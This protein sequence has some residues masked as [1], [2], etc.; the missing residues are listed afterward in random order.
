MV[1]KR[2]GIIFVN[3][4]VLSL[5]I[6]VILLLGRYFCTPEML[7]YAERYLLKEI[8][9]IEMEFDKKIMDELLG[10][11][12]TS[13]AET[14]KGNM[15]YRSAWQRIVEET[16]YKENQAATVW[17]FQ[18][19]ELLR[20]ALSEDVQI[21]LY[22]THNAETYAGSYGVSKVTGQNGGVVQAAKVLAESLE[23]KYGIK[24]WHSEVLHDYPDWSQSYN[25][26]LK[27]IRALLNSNPKTKVVFDVH[28]DAGYNNKASSTVQIKG[29]DAAVILLVIGANHQNWQ[30]NLAF[31]QMLE[32]KAAELY[33]GLFK[34]IRIAEKNRYN[35]QAHEHSVIVEVGSDL[36]TQEEAN[37][38]M[39]C[40]AHI[41]AEVMKTM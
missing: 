27:T 29:N 35:Q 14:M 40:F 13:L 6:A 38:S 7:A 37:Y 32:K 8:L 39:E 22:H 18:L 28:R 30:E 10:Y 33:P 21:I 11:D 1:R 15:V 20:P 16:L 17:N 31:A 36:N 2:K 12:G 9:C 26:S 3:K 34:G 25:N 41:C 5:F 4:I 23:R 19:K 24:V